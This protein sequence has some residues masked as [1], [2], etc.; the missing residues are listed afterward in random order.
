MSER[1]E[2]WVRAFVLTPHPE[3]G[4]FRETFRS[5]ERVLAAAL[6]ARF[7]G[8]RCLATSI[9]YL[10][11]A[12]QCSR[13][14]RLRADETWWHHAGGELH[15]HVLEPG[16]ARRIVV[17]PGSPQAV[18]PHGTWFAAEPAPGSQY[19]LAGCGTA[20]GFEYEDFELAERE[21]LLA[22]HPA[23]RDLVLRFTRGPEVV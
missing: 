10:L 12:G 22:E 21:R 13:F 7:P 17:G 20:P 6:P 8:E 23:Q 9:L 19:A 2:H 4:W 14:H 16:G 1:V 11:A 18:V 15:L 5:P 3:G